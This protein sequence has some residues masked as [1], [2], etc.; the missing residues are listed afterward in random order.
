[1]IVVRIGHG[2]SANIRFDGK[3]AVVYRCV[4]SHGVG[5]IFGTSFFLH[6]SVEFTLIPLV[7]ALCFRNSRNYGHLPRL[8]PDDVRGQL[9]HLRDWS[10]KLV[11]KNP[12]N[13]SFWVMRFSLRSFVS[14]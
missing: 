13:Y 3:L 12:S 4:R 9:N 7:L 14:V 6:V 11:H 10:K 5:K 2:L 8:L 1:V